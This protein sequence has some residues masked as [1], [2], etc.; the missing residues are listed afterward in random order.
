MKYS[1]F[2]EIEQ[3]YNDGTIIVA[4]V[5]ISENRFIGVR[6]SIIG[7]LETLPDE[8]GIVTINGKKYCPFSIEEY[9][10]L[11]ADENR[12]QN[13]YMAIFQEEVRKEIDKEIIEELY[14]ARSRTNPKINS[15]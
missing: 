8:Y 13:E 7:K 6:D 5:D 9:K 3:W 4:D 14:N 10:A 15:Q 11:S 1:N 2:K 12:W